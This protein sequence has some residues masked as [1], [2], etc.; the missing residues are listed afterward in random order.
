VD[1][2]VLQVSFLSNDGGLGEAIARALGDGF[3]LRTNGARRVDELQ[4]ILEWSDVLF[5]DLRRS[6]L[7]TEEASL[8][9]LEEICLRPGH[10][11]VLTLCDAEDREFLL[12]TMAKGATGSVPNPPN[13]VELRLLF[14]SAYRVFSAER[15][16]KRVRMQEMRGG[17]LHDLLG[18][19]SCMQE[20]FALVGRVGP[21]DVNVLI[22][23]ETGTGKELLAASSGH[24]SD[25]AKK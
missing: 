20:L 12:R 4:E 19:S 11:P 23:G 10:P 9:Q 6:N 13:I 5:L 22:T 14:R 16:L 21:C 7:Q 2:Q 25:R 3:V 15:E 1:K 17:Q 8:R 24:S 18:S